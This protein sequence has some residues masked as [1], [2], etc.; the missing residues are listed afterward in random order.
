MK[1]VLYA[2]IALMTLIV[3]PESFVQA[4]RRGGHVGFS[5]GFGSGGYCGRPGWPYRY[6]GWYGDPWFYGPAYPPYIVERDVYR[7]PKGPRASDLFDAIS[8][9]NL[10]QV[11]LLSKDINLNI[12]SDGRQ[13]K[14]PLMWAVEH[15]QTAIVEWLFTQNANINAQD[16]SKNTALHLA[17]NKQDDIMAQLLLEH[18]ALVDVQ[19][20]KGQTALHIAVQKGSEPLV[21]LLITRGANPN[22]QD[23][24]RK[25]ALDLAVKSKNQNIIN[26]CSGPVR[27]TT[28]TNNGKN[29]TNAS[30][31]ITP[32][33]PVKGS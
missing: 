30:R 31:S 10:D 7:E 19:N 21:M 32:R 13:G 4:N 6:G 9:G 27:I 12:S 17:A 20:K 22:L 15:G 3:T 18:G 28:N 1:K 5:I 23:K 26:A 14:T 16:R 33:V 2:L 11:K 8:R 29:E 25:S 24:N